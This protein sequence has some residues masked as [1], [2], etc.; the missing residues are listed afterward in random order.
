MRRRTSGF[1]IP[2]IKKQ[3]PIKSTLCTCFPM[4]NSMYYSRCINILPMTNAFTHII[5]FLF[6]HPIHSLQSFPNCNFISSYVKEKNLLFLEVWV[7]GLAI[8][9][10]YN[11]Q[12]FRE[13]RISHYIMR[14]LISRNIQCEFR[15]TE[16]K[17]F[18]QVLGAFIALRSSRS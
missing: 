9:Y 6:T 13:M 10:N 1:G 2:T 17:G 7:L 8:H 16:N 12:K 5:S 3:C 18:F 15:V 11:G 4:K 14:N